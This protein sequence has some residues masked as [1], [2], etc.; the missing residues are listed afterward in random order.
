[1]TDAYSGKRARLFTVNHDAGIVN[2]HI[3]VAEFLEHACCKLFDAVQVR[4]IEQ[5]E[6]SFE[7]CLG[8]L[9]LCRVAAR[10]VATGQNDLIA[11]LGELTRS[12]EAE[13]LERAGNDCDFRLHGSPP[14]AQ[15]R[16]GKDVH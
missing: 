9:V 3:H 7:T 11:L 6:F 16:R 8:E 4:G 1:M 2:E 5:L 15:S 13:A 10:G 12:L 14:L